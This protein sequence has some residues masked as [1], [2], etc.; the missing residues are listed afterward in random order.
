MSGFF[1]N[2][3]HIYYILSAIAVCI[4]LITVL[5][6]YSC[7]L[8]NFFKTKY[9]HLEAIHIKVEKIFSEITP[10]HG[11]SIKDKV[12]SLESQVT[13]IT[14]LTEKMFYRQK[15]ILDKS[16]SAVFESDSEGK[17]VWVNAKYLK[18]VKRDFGFVLG[19]GWRNVICPEDR[20]RVIQNWERCV[21]DGIDSED[22]YYIV[23]SKGVKIKVFCAACRTEQYGY[24]G[25]L[26][27]IN[28]ED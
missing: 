24:I 14:Q 6:K 9:S 21:K 20:D 15:W 7:R 12:N 5:F 10:N 17:C 11:S 25:A 13:K 22:T 1:S 3:S 2:P 19:N 26:E 18:L 8:F 4:G 16:D 28:D 27:V 23:D